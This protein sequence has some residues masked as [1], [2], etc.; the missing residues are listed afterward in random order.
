MLS[1]LTAARQGQLGVADQEDCD[2]PKKI[3]KVLWD[4]QVFFFF[5]RFSLLSLLL[6][7]LRA[8]GDLKKRSFGLEQFLKVLRPRATF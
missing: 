6:N 5:T 7:L 4:K 8:P 2:R 3:I 1:L